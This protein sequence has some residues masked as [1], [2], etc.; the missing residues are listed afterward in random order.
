MNS[1][2][3]LLPLLLQ[4]A[5]TMQIG[6]AVLNLFLIRLMKWRE[7]LARTPLLL[8][9]VFQVHVWFIS[10]TLAIFGILTWRFAG[11][12]AGGEN[13]IAAWLAAGIGLFWG[14]RTVLQV[15]Y[16]SSSHW[17]RQVGRTIAHVT[18]LMMYGGMAVLYLCAA[19]GG[20]AL[21]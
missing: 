19:F 15:I 18:L 7:E 10:I 9:E 20:R 14:I 21:K 2:T 17:R 12:I 13:E 3:Y 5:A 16:Y 1:S 4:L 11:K 8:R 6:V